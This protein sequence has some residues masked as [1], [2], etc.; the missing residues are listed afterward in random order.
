[1]MTKF[2]LKTTVW[3]LSIFIFTPI[4]WTSCEEEEHPNF[5]GVVNPNGPEEDY[6]TRFRGQFQ[7]YMAGRL[8][9]DTICITDYTRARQSENGDSIVMYNI[10]FSN[11]MPVTLQAIC[12]SDVA[13]TNGVLSL[14]HDS[15]IP[16]MKMSGMWIPYDDKII[17]DFYGKLTSDSLILEMKCGGLPLYYKGGRVNASK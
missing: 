2:S 14:R 4:F 11:Y 6:T 1:M 3:L 9:R 16:A 8:D 5:G 12:I 10:K 13:N 7:T 17:T 15:I